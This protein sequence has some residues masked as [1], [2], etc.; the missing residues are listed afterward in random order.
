MQLIKQLLEGKFLRI[1]A[2]G[3]TIFV[4]VIMLVPISKGP[5]INFPYADKIVHSIIYFVFVIVWLTYF[6]ISEKE[7]KRIYLIV[8]LVLFVYGIVIEV[9][10]G[11]VVASRAHDNWDIVANTIGIILG[12]IVFY[13]TKDVFLSKK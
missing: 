7:N 8:S 6:L 3:Y 12:V 10:Q 2:I 1:I 5:T 9:L 11:S 4:T 13:K